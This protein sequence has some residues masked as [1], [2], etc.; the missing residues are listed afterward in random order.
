MKVGDLIIVTPYAIKRS[1]SF[2]R[3]ATDNH[4]CSSVQ[5]ANRKGILLSREEVAEGFVMT[6]AFGSTVIKAYQDYFEI[7]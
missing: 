7:I 5:F 2:L 4:I 6:V 3:V 1:V